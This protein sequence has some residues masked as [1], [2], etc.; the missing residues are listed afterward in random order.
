[1][2]LTDQQ[3]DALAREAIQHAQRGDFA[4]AERLFARLVEERPNSG[5]GLHLLGQ[6]RLKLGRFAEAR[7]P[8]ERAARFL[9][10][11]LGAQVNFAGC[12]SVLGEHEAALGALDRAH[13]LKPGDP[14]IAHNRGRALEALGR[15]DEALEAFGDA[16]AANHRLLPALSARASLLARRG[17]WMGA[18]TDLDMALTG[19]PGNV[20]L[21]L[22]R[23]ELLLGQ[24]DWLRGLPDYEARLELKEIYA[25]GLPR[26]QGETVAGQLL[27]YPEQVDIE[28]DQALHD[29][30][31]LARGL[32]G[33]VPAVV[34]CSDRL[35]GHLGLPTTRRGAP[36][37][38]F[39]AA[40]PLRSLPLLMGWTLQSLPA[41]P[42]PPTLQP[43]DRIGWFGAAEPP[44]GLRIERDPAMIARCRRVVGDDNWQ[45]CLAARLGI[46]TE[47][48][49]PA[50]A[51]WLWG[52]ASGPSPWFAKLTIQ[53]A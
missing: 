20:Q 26:W 28:S 30:L 46:E 21:R 8:L 51:D 25:P 19:E 7:E 41:P 50:T 52:P 47:M 17:D 23:A 10:R 3:I 5:Q 22:R 38:G 15:L 18:L 37:D 31:L 2:A 12:L 9:P 29:T 45:T 44:P 40:V 27:L 16:L 53:R 39:T 43:D 13:E 42:A 33:V 48:H 11:D 14:V 36:L 1:M 32:E 34:Q 4:A 35:A 24:G 6:A 49:L